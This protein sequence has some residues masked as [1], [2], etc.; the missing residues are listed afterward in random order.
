MT[1]N[2]LV[3]EE[4]YVMNNSKSE[5]V[6]SYESKG[7]KNNPKGKLDALNIIFDIKNKISRPTSAA[8]LKYLE[9]T[10]IPEFSELSN[11]CYDSLNKSVMLTFSAKLL[12]DDFLALTDANGDS[13][14]PLVNNFHQ[15]LRMSQSISEEKSTR[16][17]NVWENNQMIISWK[18]KHPVIIGTYL[19]YLRLLV[20]FDVMLQNL[21][22][23]G[24][25]I[26]EMNVEPVAVQGE[27]IPIN[28]HNFFNQPVF[29]VYENCV[30]SVSSMKHDMN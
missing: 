8:K 21:E 22:I 28:S 16:V 29:N 30:K 20:E 5:L 27:L 19:T 12:V 24:L 3:S 18:T 26:F 15:P 17:S 6:K 9:S 25:S 2:K 7:Q 4:I 10:Y 13:T 23:P 1:T 14:Q 11:Q